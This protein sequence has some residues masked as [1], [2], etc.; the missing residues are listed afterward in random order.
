MADYDV[1]VAGGGPV[2]TVAGFALAQAGLKVLVA[3]ADPVLREDLRASTFHP[4]S[5][6][7]LEALGVLEPLMAQGLSN[8]EISNQL[9]IAM[10]TV[11]FHVTNI[12]AKLHANNRT[13]AVLT[14]LKHKLVLLA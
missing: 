14:A 1:I 5:L 3:E 7:M 10:P 8:Q 4:S 11:K 13:E 6:E 12:L 9:S 2:G